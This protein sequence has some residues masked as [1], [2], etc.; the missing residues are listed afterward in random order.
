M[1]MRLLLFFF[2]CWC[3]AQ[4]HLLGVATLGV[5]AAI[6]RPL[7]FASIDP[8]VAARPGDTGAH[9]VG[10]VPGP[11]GRGGGGG[12]SDH[13]CPA[14]VRVARHGPRLP[15]SS[16]RPLLVLGLVLSI[17]IALTVTWLGLA[18]SYFYDQPVSSTSR[19][20]RSAPTCSPTPVGGWRSATPLRSSDPERE[21]RGVR[22][23]DWRDQASRT[24]SSAAALVAGTAIAAASGLVG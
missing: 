5:L 21:R 7:L 19:R 12:Q 3:L 23:R 6:A 20:S 18:L 14:G 15:R 9:A 4:L 13:G 24:R 22:D 2:F 1:A 11:A 16:P 8:D 10:G 17:G